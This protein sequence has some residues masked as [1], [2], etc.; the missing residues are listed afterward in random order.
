[1][2]APAL[3]RKTNVITTVGSSQPEGGRVVND[4]FTCGSC[5]HRSEPRLSA[6]QCSTADITSPASSSTYASSEGAL[7][8][9]RRAP[10]RRSGTRRLP[11]FLNDGGS[12]S[13]RPHDDTRSEWWNQ[14]TRGLAFS[15][16]MQLT[17]RWYLW[18]PEM[19]TEAH[20]RGRTRGIEC[21]EHIAPRKTRCPKR[22]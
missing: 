15:G 5:P 9:R 13:D 7:G 20:E 22:P 12:S 17:F 2:F 21:S 3:A 10:N 19:L 14:Y 16:P 6:L 11:Q 4:T 18:E 8:Q 1:M